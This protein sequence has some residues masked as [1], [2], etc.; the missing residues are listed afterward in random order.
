MSCPGTIGAAPQGFDIAPQGFDIAPG[1]MTTLMDEAVPLLLARM[2]KPPRR[3]LAT[4]D[5]AAIDRAIPSS[6]PQKGGGAARLRQILLEEFLPLVRD[7]RH[8]LHL[9]HQRPAPSFASLYADVAAPV[10]LPAGQQWPP[11]TLTALASLP[12][13]PVGSV[14]PVELTWAG[15]LDGTRR[16]SLRLIAADGTLVAQ[17]DDGLDAV[18]RIQLFVPPDAVPGDYSLHLMVYDAETLDPIPAAD[19]QQIV[20]VADIQIGDP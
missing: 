14:L 16:L 8:P 13:A 6:L 1:E 15:P 5:R 7:Y 12:S 2:T 18:N 17:V 19:G 3:T 9:G 10:P 11:M 4:L 20:Q